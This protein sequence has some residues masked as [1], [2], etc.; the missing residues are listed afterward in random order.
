MKLRQ[1][2]RKTSG[3]QRKIID[4]VGVQVRCKHGGDGGWRGEKGWVL[5]SSCQWVH[6]LTQ[7]P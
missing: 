3:W 7:P 1:W 2:L 6:H 5:A 4:D